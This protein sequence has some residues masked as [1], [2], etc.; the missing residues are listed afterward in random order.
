MAIQWNSSLE[1]GVK[2]VDE[3][4]KTL[5]L[6]INKLTDAMKSGNGKQEVLNVLTFLEKYAAQHFSHEESCMDRHKCPAALAN[7]KAHAEFFSYFSQV[8]STIEKENVTTPMVLDLHTA[9][10]DWLRNHILKIDTTLRTCVKA[11][12]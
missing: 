12:A 8:K 5:I 3:A 7:R 6:W 2:E 4:H 11:S 1:T 9:L 10:S